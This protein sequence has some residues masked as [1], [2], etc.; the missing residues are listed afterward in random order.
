MGTGFK[1]IRIPDT[2]EYI[3]QFAFQDCSNLVDIDLGSVKVLGQGVFKNCSSLQAITL[4]DTITELEYGGDGL[5]YYCKKLSSITLPNK[6]IRVSH[7]MLDYTAYYENEAN[8]QDGV[9]Y[10]GKYLI[11]VNDKFTATTYSVKEGTEVIAD[12]A[13]SYYMSNSKLTTVTL[14]Q[15][16]KIIGEQAFY[17]YTAL[18]SCN[19]P[20][21]VEKIG[22]EAFRYT[23]LVKEG[24]TN[25]VGNW[26]IN[27]VLGSG[28][29]TLTVKEGTVGIA[30]GQ[31]TG[32]NNS[33][34]TKINLPNSLK[35]IGTENFKYFQALT[36][37]TSSAALQ[38]I[39]NNAFENC[40]ALQEFDL[41]KS[42]GLKYIGDTAFS[43]CKVYDNIYIPKSVVYLGE[44][45]FNNVTGTI[46]IEI[47][48][49]E[50]PDSWNSS[51]NVTY[52][53]ELKIQWGISIHLPNKYCSIY[54]NT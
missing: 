10:V 19:I 26:L 20:D 6:A 52:G 24:Q 36:T 32:S 17:N 54:L 49:A 1:Q 38:S 14:P 35:Y 39:G 4:P 21:S 23:L 37:V 22:K 30:D 43:W 15:G 12:N 5:F 47:N 25:Y 27:Y 53:P 7:S 3:G 28:E 16:L 45:V 18:S 40:F 9:L 34:V 13:F 41:S 48:Q 50:I 29:T 2:V 46:S 33:T 11:A 51:W 44:D 31:M 42:T 8:W